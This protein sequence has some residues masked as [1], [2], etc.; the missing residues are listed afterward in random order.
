[1]FWLSEIKAKLTSAKTLRCLDFPSSD[2]ITE[3]GSKTPQK[4]HVTGL[5]GTRQ[6]SE[7]K[8]MRFSFLSFFPH[9]SHLSSSEATGKCTTR[10][11]CR[12]RDQA[13]VSGQAEPAVYQASNTF[14]AGKHFSRKF[15][16]CVVSQEPGSGHVLI[17]EL[18]S[19]SLCSDWASPFQI[20]CHTNQFSVPLQNT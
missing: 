10:G 12:T 13:Q 20:T 3:Q 14:S 1:M 16:H 8:I 5:P 18:S 17:F 4:F 15:Q 7:K 2:R 19:P 6:S 11:L 9:Y